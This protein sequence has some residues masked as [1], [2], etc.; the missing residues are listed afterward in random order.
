MR[1]YYHHV[2]ACIRCILMTANHLNIKLDL[3]SIDL[4][5][6][7]QNSEEFLKMNPNYSVLVLED[8]EFALW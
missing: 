4:F 2:S 1:L 6:K 3:V 7:E 5:K 8:G